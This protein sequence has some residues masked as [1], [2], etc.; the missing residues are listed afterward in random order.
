MSDGGSPQ[1]FSEWDRQLG[2]YIFRAKMRYQ[3]REEE[4]TSFHVKAWYSRFR[5]NWARLDR[6]NLDPWYPLFLTNKARPNPNLNTCDENA[7]K[8][9]VLHDVHWLFSATLL[10]SKLMLRL[11]RWQGAATEEGLLCRNRGERLTTTA[12]AS[13]DKISILGFSSI[14][15]LLC[16]LDAVQYLAETSLAAC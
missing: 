2:L 12:F 13:W 14:L 7:G 1:K 3:I 4:A 10:F 11:W 8:H 5:G 16:K 15:L 6:I 9:K